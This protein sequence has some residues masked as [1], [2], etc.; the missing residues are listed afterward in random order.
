M[1]SVTDDLD[2]RLRRI[3]TYCEKYVDVLQEYERWDDSLIKSS[4]SCAGGPRSLYLVDNRRFAFCAVPKAATSSI[5]ALILLAQN[6]SAKFTDADSIYNTFFHRFRLLCPS[7]YVRHHVVTNYTRVII[8]RH[9]FERL[10][11]AYVNKVRTSR[12]KL[13][14]VKHLYKGGFSG[15]GPNGTYTFAEFVKIILNMPVQKW[16]SHWAPYTTR[17]RPCTMRVYYHVTARCSCFGGFCPIPPIVTLSVNPQ[18]RSRYEADGTNKRLPVSKKRTRTVDFRWKYAY[19]A[20]S[21]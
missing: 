3:N 4:V 20:P 19:I 11:S 14:A 13:S 1:P 15:R 12:P 2:E 17:C 6:A 16:D 7:E 21:P 9:P 8:V 5:K 18:A 10:V